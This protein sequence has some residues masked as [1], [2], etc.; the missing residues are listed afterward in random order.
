MN[1]QKVEGDRDIL[2]L[3]EHE[4]EKDHRLGLLIAL[5]LPAQH[6]EYSAL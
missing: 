2:L 3:R 6:Q 4:D 5:H 1:N